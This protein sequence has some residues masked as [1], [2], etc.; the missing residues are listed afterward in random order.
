LTLLAGI[1]LE[2]LDPRQAFRNWRIA[3]RE[4]RKQKESAAHVETVVSTLVTRGENEK[5]EP[6][7]SPAA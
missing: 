2:C 1:L 5:A 7:S 4:N 6:V 3:R